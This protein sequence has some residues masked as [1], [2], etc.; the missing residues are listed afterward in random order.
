MAEYGTR[1]VA[2]LVPVAPALGADRLGRAS[3][4]SCFAQAGA[5]EDGSEPA[6]AGEPA[7][8]FSISP[9]KFNGVPERDSRFPDPYNMGVHA[10]AFLYDPKFP[11]EPKTRLM[12][13]YKR[14]REIS[15][16]RR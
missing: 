16:S 13:Y 5:L 3:S 1:A 4:T 7:R 15:T 2:Q 10:E 14:L 6:P 8:L 9:W 11:P 12:M